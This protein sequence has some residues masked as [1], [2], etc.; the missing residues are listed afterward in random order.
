MNQRS[1]YFDN[2]KGFLIFLVVLGHLLSFGGADNIA[3][4]TLWY[5]L[6]SFHM[7][8][9]IFVTGA[10][11]RPHPDNVER[12]VKR[13]LI[14]YVVFDVL[15]WLFRVVFLQEPDI[16]FTLINPQFAMW[17]L[18]ACFWYRI[19]YNFYSGFKYGLLLA[20]VIA[21]FTPFD[22]RVSNTLAIARTL[23][24]LPFFVMGT[25][26]SPDWITKFTDRQ[27]QTAFIVFM[28]AMVLL[29]VGAVNLHFFPSRL[30]FRTSY[31]DY[32]DP[33]Y[34][35]MIW[36]VLIFVWAA[37]TIVLVL[38]WMPTKKTIFTKAGRHSMNVYLFHIFVIK[39]MEYWQ[40]LDGSKPVTV[41][42]C[43][44]TAAGLT[45]L[46]SRD[47]FQRLYDWILYPFNWLFD[48]IYSKPPQYAEKD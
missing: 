31:D 12:A 44:L 42:L 30:L 33:Q 22:V 38:I 11:T 18:L 9:F 5:L 14:P 7:P 35:E 17:Y 40:L 26:F 48:H 25:K 27:R 23:T 19:F 41:V 47:I 28:A 3:G 21:L 1:E 10:L 46:F 29:A 45:W 6:F 20:F 37:F 36:R 4:S 13:L 32:P 34:L 43:I 24:F 15:I 39:F 16:P 8:L 2:L